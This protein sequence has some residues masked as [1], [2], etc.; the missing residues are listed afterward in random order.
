M[1]RLLLSFCLMVAFWGAAP[2]DPG[3]SP[4]GIY[5][6]RRLALDT[7]AYVDQSGANC[8][9]VVTP[10]GVVVIDTGGSSIY[11]KN[12]LKA[13]SGV[14]DRNIRYVIN[15]Q[16][17]YESTFGNCIV[18]KAATI[19]A[20]SNC[21]SALSEKGEQMLHAMR[22]E[23]KPGLDD[24]TI[25]LPIRLVWRSKDLAVFGKKISLIPA[26]WAHSPGDLCV[27][28]PEEKVLFAGDLVFSNY[29]PDLK[30]ANTRNWLRVLTTLAALKPEIVVPAHGVLCDDKAIEKTGDFLQALRAKVKA[31]KEAGVTKE[32]AVSKIDLSDYSE[33]I[34]YKELVGVAIEKAYDEPK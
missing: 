32:E 14:T 13:I 9:F 7:Y 16:Y 10:E 21:K 31:A 12:L 8:G 25:K 23:G 4:A 27:W 5:G 2:A 29:M 17:D 33:L 20:H 30:D 15:T 1:A 11:A 28:L 19:V 6:A 26:T 24:I 34:G 22:A 3:A 18:G